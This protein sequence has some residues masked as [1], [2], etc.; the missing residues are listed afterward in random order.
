MSAFSRRA[1]LTTLASAAALPGA[2]K[3]KPKNVLFIAVDDLNDW[4][5]C[6]G[7][8]PDVKTPNIDRLA[9]KGM[10]FTKAYCAA[11]SCNPSRASLMTGIRPSTSGVYE[12]RQPMRQSSVLKDAVTMPSHFAAHGY[13]VVGGGKIFHGSF[14]DPASWQEYFPSQEKNQPPNPLPEGRPVNGMPRTAH[15]D[16]GP[17]PVAD[18]EMG[19]SK[20]VD[21]AMKELNE[22]HDKPFFLACGIYRPHLPWYVPQKYFEMYPADKITLPA[23]KD[24]DLD[25]VPA[26]GKHLAIRSGD[27]KKVIEYG[28]WRK[29]V[30]GYLASISFADACVGRLLDALD[31]SPHASNTIVVLWS[32][33]GWSLGEKL[34]WRKFA[35]WE[36]ATRN[37]LIMSVPGMTKAGSKCAR[38]VDSMHIY[39]TMIE[40]C[41]LSP[42]KE[43]EGKSFV[44]LLQSPAAKWDLP[45]I[46]TYE[47]NNH[48][49][50]SERWRYIRYHDGGEEL[51]D[52]SND[53]LEWNNLAGKPE[54][55]QVKEEHARW[56][57]KVNAMDSPEV[58]TSGEIA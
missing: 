50:R 37:V 27:H 28:Q 12:N 22:K 38:T 56:L 30:Q 19:D 42:K 21:W 10:L 4:I 1:F 48:S 9:A 11:P 29:A 33:H 52:H 7:G 13:R 43:L 2:L 14:P 15:F 24:D 3:S 34:H 8:H 49:V 47:R 6:L 57:P 39:P 5:G 25:D 58:Q 35:L 41:G 54:F 23:V 18:S 55:S 32:D 17:V 53:D 20:T 45:A 44:S 31:R 16:W 46:T 51:Y 40:L 36:E 26:V